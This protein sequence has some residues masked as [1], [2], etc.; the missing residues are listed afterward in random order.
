MRPPVAL[1]LYASDHPRRAV[2][3][4]FTRFSPE[5]QALR[6][7]FARGIPARFM[8]LPQAIQLARPEP[9]EEMIPPVDGPEPPSGARP[10]DGTKT[11]HSVQGSKS[12]RTERS[13]SSVADLP[14]CATTRWACSPKRR[15][16]TTTSSG[17]SGRSS[18]GR[19]GVFEGILEAMRALRCVNPNDEEAQREA[20][21]RETI[22]TAQH[23]GYPDRRRLRGVASPALVPARPSRPTPRRCAASSVNQGRCHLD[24]LDKLAAGLPQRLW[25][26]RHLAGLVRAS[27]DGS[28]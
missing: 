7:A 25:R 21:M 5:W 3:Y 13:S 17:G 23:E 19:T 8:D 11:I 27:L 26:R 20:H 4:P 10:I 16:T 24:S 2:Y 28:R 6:Y 18:S 12:V 1:L 15:A 9:V 22:R 14:R